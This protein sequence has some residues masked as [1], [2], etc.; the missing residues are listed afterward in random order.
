MSLSITNVVDVSILISP[1]AKE[2]QSFGKLVFVTD[3]TPLVMGINRIVAYKGLDEVATDWGVDSQVHKAATTYYGNGGKD[4]MV[5]TAA[6]AETS[7][8]LRGGMPAQL[9]ELQAVTAGGFTITVNGVRQFLTG[10]DLSGVSTMDEVAGVLESVIKGVKVTFEGTWFRIQTVKVGREASITVTT[11]DIQR[12]GELLGLSAIAGATVVEAVGAKTPAE[13]LALAADIDPSFY[14]IVLH[15]KWRDSEAAMAV[16]EYA[17]GS[18]R[19]FFNTSNDHNCL[20]KA[21]ETNI[22]AKIKAKS[23]QRTLSHYSSYDVEYPSAAVAGR[24]FQVNFEGT[25]T[26]IT[27]NLKVLPGVTVEKLKQSEKDALESHNGN[28]VVDIAGVFVYSDSRMGDGTWFDAVHGVDWL[29][30]RIETG[31]FNRMYTTTRKIPYTDSG[32]SRIIA[33][34]EQACRQ[35]VTNGLLAPG[36]TAEG[37]YL[38]LGYKVE[39]IPTSEVSQADKANR[40]Y[41]GITFQTVGA[42]ALHKVVVSG[43]F[44]E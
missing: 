17:Q 14:G 26:T 30:N 7:A 36:N 23:L 20:V 10:V 2:L 3:E 24:A 28:T 15:K 38:P 5:T 4:F 1:K 35:G 37:E 42:G 25:N 29:Q 27:L 19:V 40:T 39:Y 8:T 34:I 9:A 33:E 22:M 41:K 21:D 6:A 13:A 12:L 44:N 32:V 31:I 18:R 11:A 16:A 43:T